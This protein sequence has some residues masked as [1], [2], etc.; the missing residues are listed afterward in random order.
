MAVLYFTLKPWG[1]FLCLGLLL[2]SAC[3]A[4]YNGSCS[5]FKEILSSPGPNIQ[6]EP[7]AYT[8][9]NTYKVSLLVN[10]NINFVLLKAMDKNNHPVGMWQNADKLCNDGALYQVDTSHEVPFWA[11]WASP[12]STNV[13]PVKLQVFTVYSNRQAAVSSLELKDKT[14][15]ASPSKTST[16]RSPPTPAPTSV[17]IRTPSIALTTSISSA[18]TAFLS[19]I[20][21]AIQILLIFL[22]GKLLF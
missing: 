6:V 14:S 9:N 21:G 8:S 1:L 4:E 20:T 13:T 15:T 12:P 10:K 19:P 22:T 7:N 5:V 18:S 17:T 2:P 11:F 16:S 3:M